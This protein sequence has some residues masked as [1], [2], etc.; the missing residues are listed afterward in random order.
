[1]ISLDFPAREIFSGIT[2]TEE[3]MA[4]VR[5]LI[6]YDGNITFT[7]IDGRRITLAE[8]FL[9]AYGVCLEEPK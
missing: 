1:L 9:K 6:R 5:H 8:Q 3:R 7:V 4:K 2:T